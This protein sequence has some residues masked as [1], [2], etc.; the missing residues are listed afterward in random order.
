MLVAAN[1]IAGDRISLKAF[2]RI[3][4]E[5]FPNSR[6]KV[7]GPCQ[8]IQTTDLAGALLVAA[9]NGKQ[10]FAYIDINGNI[11]LG[12]DRSTSLADS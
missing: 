10:H 9:Y 8:D 11:P 6:I 2:S 12:S 1:Q 7:T 4:L 5:F 3:F